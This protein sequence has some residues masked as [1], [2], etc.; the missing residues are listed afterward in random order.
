MAAAT[1]A[2]L[3]GPVVCR[4]EPTLSV[5]DVWGYRAV[6]VL[7]VLAMTAVCLGRRL[8]RLHWADGVALFWWVAVSLNFLFLPSFPAAEVYGEATAMMVAYMS[9]R[10]IVPYCGR[11]FTRFWR[12]GLCLAGGYEL[13][14]GGMQLAGCEAFRHH[15]F[16]V[17]GTFFNPGPYAVFVAVV[18]AVAVALWYRSVKDRTGYGRW[19]KA[20]IWSVGALTVVGIPVLV[21]TWSR[22][23]WLALAIAVACLLWHRHRRAVLA[24][25]A[26]AAVA[27]VAVYF[28]KQGS[29]DGRW[30]MTAVAGRAW[31]EAWLTGHGL[32]SYVHAYGE[33]QAAFFAARPG[34]PLAGVAGSPEFAFNGLLGVAV[35][36][37]LAGIVPALWLGVWSLAALWRRDEVTAAGWLVL[38]VAS[39]FS[40]PFAIWPFRLMAAGWLAMAV[41]GAA[42]TVPGRWWKK[43]VALP[44]AVVAMV[45]IWDLSAGMAHKVAVYESFRRISGIQDAA[46]LDDY[47]EMYKDLYASPDFLFTFGKALQAVG[48]HND[49]NAVLHQGTMVSCDPMFH[50]LI[51]NNYR[52]LGAP[53]EAEKAYTKAFDMLPDR[54]YPLYRLMG[55]Y[56]SVGRT[57]KARQTA[58]RI[59]ALKPKVDSPAVREMKAEAWQLINH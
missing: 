17:T 53:A 26:V 19:G 59:V 46:F 39:Q 34:S 35:E 18:L 21:A 42:G 36:Q 58:R 31:T 41:S 49:S 10:L 13:W 47:E 9:L 4:T 50:V 2:T 29:A 12:I 51:G 38:L 3:C 1:V 6:A 44:P 55:L 11:A 57:D 22:T 5:S 56:Q 24:G 33:A 54:L 32:G 23:A 48:R 30:L 14:K 37:G 25:V 40:Y 15:L 43:A 45:W 7:A 20:G 8:P 27:G 16:G 28:L 52:A